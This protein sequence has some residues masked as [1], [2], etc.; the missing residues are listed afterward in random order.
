MASKDHTADIY[1]IPSADDLRINTATNPLGRPI[2]LT[3]EV[4]DSQERLLTRLA[5]IHMAVNVINDLLANSDAFR[6][7]Q[8]SGQPNAPG[9]WPLPPTYVEGLFVAVRFLSE[10]AESLSLGALS[11]TRIDD[12]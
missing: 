3:D 6:E 12:V 7:R 2:Y 8:A 4:E 1:T 10:Y 5:G 9:E 11:E